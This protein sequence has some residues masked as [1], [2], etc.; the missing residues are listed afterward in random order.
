MISEPRGLE[1]EPRSRIFSLHIISAYRNPY[2]EAHV[3]QISG[4]SERSDRV[5]TGTQYGEC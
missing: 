4:P 3:A 2:D 5:L 1:F